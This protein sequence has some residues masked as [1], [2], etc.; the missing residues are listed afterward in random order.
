MS[1]VGFQASKFW[2][3]FWKIYCGAGLEII[4][5]QKYFPNVPY[6]FIFLTFFFMVWKNQQSCESW[7]V[8]FWVSRYSKM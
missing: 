8:G 6:F 2:K 7:L 4:F 5:R 3:F 1:L